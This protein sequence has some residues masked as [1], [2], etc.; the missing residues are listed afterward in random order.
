MEVAQQA[1]GHCVEKLA[2][3]CIALVSSTASKE[4]KIDVAARA[5]SFGSC[6]RGFPV[7]DTARAILDIRNGVSE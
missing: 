4:V 7:E 6:V 1:H 5:E 3:Y 2:T